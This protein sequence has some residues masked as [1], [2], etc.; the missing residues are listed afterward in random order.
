MG[1]STSSTGAGS[2]ASFDPPWLDDA[3]GGIDS[4]HADKPISPS[5]APAETPDEADTQE[6]GPSSP[7][8]AGPTVA[9]P[10]RYQEARRALTG[11][12]R[13]GSGS[14]LRRGMSSFVKKGLGEIKTF[15]IASASEAVH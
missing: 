8:E 12:V 10:G 15:V 2:G 1:T 6:G 5:T 4:G 13:S 3:E 7:P 14:D 11:F 9:P